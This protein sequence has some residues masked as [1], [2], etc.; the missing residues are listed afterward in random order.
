M[1][2]PPELVKHLREKNVILFTG[3]GVSM[4]LGLP[5]W[6]KL[7]DY[8]A[9]LLGYDPT[10]FQSS[11]NYLELAEYYRIKEGSLE[12]LVQ[13]MDIH[14]HANSIDVGACPIYKQIVQLDWHQIYTTNNDNWLERA[15]KHYNKPFDKL[16]GIADFTKS[17]SGETQ[18]IKYHGDFEDHESIVLTE[19]SYFDRLSKEHAL[20][21]KLK[22]DS[23]GKSILFIGYSLSDL[24]IR[25]L[26]YKLQCLW[27][28]SIDHELQPKSYIFLAKENPIQDLVLEHRNVVP[29]VSSEENPGKALEKFLNTLLEAIK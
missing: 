16:I 23:L 2:L 21:V 5:S 22:A 25:L 7:I 24:D 4:N 26:L 15:F 17:A 27:G 10:I 14:F 6:S 11:G 9:G 19:S 12:K 18:I 29:I 20:D 3:A 1:Q 28:E 8:M 13:W